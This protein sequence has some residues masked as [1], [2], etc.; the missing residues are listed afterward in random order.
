MNL[1]AFANASPVIQIHTLLALGAVLLTISIFA[2]RKGSPLHRVMGWTWVIMM[3][4]VALS[5]FWINE[6]RVLGAFSPI[7]LLS[8]ITLVTLVSSVT[9]ARRH[10]VKRHKRQMRTLVFGALIVAGGFT[11]LPGRLMHTVFLGG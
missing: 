8:I 10:N 11:F 6:L 2:L 4:L 5:S 7:H 1:T 9:A 3:A